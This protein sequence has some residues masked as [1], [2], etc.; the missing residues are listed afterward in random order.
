MFRSRHAMVSAFAAGILLAATAGL[1]P[2]LAK[3][4]VE[5][6]GLGAVAV[7][8][9]DVRVVSVDLPSRTI[10][11]EKRGHQW[12]V[13]V[14]ED[15]GSLAALRSRDSLQINRVESALVSVAPAKA[16]AKPDVSYSSAH[17]DGLFGGLPARWIV[18]NITATVKFDSLDAAKG[19]VSYTGPEGAQTVRVI[20]PVVMQ[21]LQKLRKGDMVTLSFSQATEFVLTPR[22]F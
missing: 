14:P 7:D 5:V 17:D 1:Q 19:L 13:T 16:G 21:A 2:A 11:V 8:N 18:R 3:S 6:R 9:I 12:R 4:S 20:D 22:R 15:A 10:V